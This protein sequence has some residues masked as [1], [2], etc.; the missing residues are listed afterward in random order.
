MY[1]KCTNGDNVPE[2]EDDQYKSLKE[3]C[4]KTQGKPFDEC[5]YK[6][7]CASPTKPPTKKPT[8]SPTYK[9]TYR[10]THKPTSKPSNEPYTKKPTPYPTKKPSPYPTEKPSPYPTKK[11]SPL[12]T[13]SPVGECEGFVWGYVPKGAPQFGGTC[14]FY[15]WNNFDNDDFIVK[16]YGSEE[17][18]CEDNFGSSSSSGDDMAGYYK[19]KED[20]ECKTFDVCRETLPPT[21]K[22]SSPPTKKPSPSP[23]KKPSTPSPTTCEERKWH[24]KGSKCSNDDISTSNDSETEVYHTMQECCEDLFGNN[25]YC[26]YE[27]VCVEPTPPPSLSPTVGSTQGSTPTVSTEKTGPPTKPAQP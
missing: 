26:K 6:D 16:L 4:Y 7:I 11:P 1:G 24:V 22:P 19:P 17:E 14:V 13:K 10:P 15:M 23:T 18:C 27:D 2:D 12:P 25:K 5:K 9:P 8:N 21:K 20:E 3:C